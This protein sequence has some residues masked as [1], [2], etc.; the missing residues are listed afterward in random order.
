L[1]PF[2]HADTEKSPLFDADGDVLA[3]FVQAVL[4]TGK[5]RPEILATD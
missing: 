4:Q 2:F 1:Q 3:E 5:G